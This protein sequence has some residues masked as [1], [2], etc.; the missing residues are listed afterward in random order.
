MKIVVFG[1]GGQLGQC[2]FDELSKSKHE[3]RFCY[4]KNCDITDFF[5]I[6]TLLMQISPNVV[7][8]AAAYTQV[9]EAERD[10]ESA[11]RVNHLAVAN[12]AGA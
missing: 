12:I 7:I 1:G 11:N 2:L 8:N 3:A 10:Q 4:R 6:K 9:V 5:G